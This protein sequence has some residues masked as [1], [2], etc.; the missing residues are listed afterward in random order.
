M[1]LFGRMSAFAVKVTVSFVMAIGSAGSNSRTALVRYLDVPMAGDFLIDSFRMRAPLDSIAKIPSSLLNFSGE[2]HSTDAGI[3]MFVT[4][5]RDTI[6]R[7]AT[8]T[9]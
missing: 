3:E 5:K 7:F 6:S 1:V 8:R 9:V 2:R 4:T